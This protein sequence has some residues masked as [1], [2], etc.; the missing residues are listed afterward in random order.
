MVTCKTNVLQVPRAT[1]DSRRGNQKGAN[2]ST[3]DDEGDGYDD[4]RDALQPDVC[5]PASATAPGSIE[6]DISGRSSA[7]HSSLDDVILG[8]VISHIEQTLDHVDRER[9][10]EKYADTTRRQRHPSYNVSGDKEN[11]GDI[12]INTG[13]TQLMASSQAKKLKIIQ[14]QIE[15]INNS[16]TPLTRDLL[17][18]DNLYAETTP[19]S[20]SFVQ[21]ER[22]TE[23]ITRSQTVH[24]VIADP[25]AHTKRTD[26][27]SLSSVGSDLQASSSYSRS[28]LMTDNERDLDLIRGRSDLRLDNDADSGFSVKGE[29]DSDDYHHHRRFSEV[30]DQLEYIRGRDDW[31]NVQAKRSAIA[32][33]V[34]TGNANIYSVTI[35]D[36]IDSD[37]YHHARRMSE[38]LDLA[39][40]GRLLSLAMDSNARTPFLDFNYRRTGDEFERAVS[41]NREIAEERVITSDRL[42]RSKQTSS[43]LL[44]RNLSPAP[45]HILI[46]D[47]SLT[48]SGEGKICEEV[49]KPELDAPSQTTPG[50][51]LDQFYDE[52]RRRSLIQ[53]QNTLDDAFVEVEV[54]RS[55]QEA[56]REVADFF[57]TSAVDTSHK[58]TSVSDLSEH[59]ADEEKSSSSISKMKKSK[60]TRNLLAAERLSVDLSANEPALKAISDKSDELKQ[61][62]LNQTTE[63]ASASSSFKRIETNDRPNLPGISQS[64][65]FLRNEKASVSQNVPRSPLTPLT[66]RTPTIDELLQETSIGP[67]FRKPPQENVDDLLQE[68]SMGPWFHN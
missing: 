54:S 14:A 47:T 13:D 63:E 10:S 50:W 60:T 49:H 28:D 65:E 5:H 53:H 16:L 51:D 9:D 57:E 34:E 3:D 46:E 59:S 32:R 17:A 4:V 27:L 8:E 61:L 18:A 38:C 62:R 41:E 25:T 26:L 15:N 29:I 21:H 12:V 56:D 55:D 52:D 36:Q 11:T 42:L 39:Y 30:N 40:S 33:L 31:K 67:W 6:A 37:E 19:S 22:T 7:S 64:Q 43:R 24:D 45:I 2:V 20:S 1:D 48:D 44:S 23:E 66:P 35:R 58:D 68:T